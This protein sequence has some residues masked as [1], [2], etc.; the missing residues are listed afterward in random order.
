MIE[1]SSLFVTLSSEQKLHLRYIAKSGSKGPAV[2][3]MHGAVEN[4]KIFYTESNKG[5]APFLASKGYRCYI[6]DLR[7]RG[8]SLPEISRQSDYGQTEAI[9]EDIPA[10]LDYITYHS[11]E[12]PK[13]WVAHSW[14][15]VLM[16]SYFARFKNM[17]DKVAAC[18]YFGSKRSLHN[19]HISKYIQ[20][21]L[22]WYG[23]APLYA[24]KHGFLPAKALRWGSDNETQKSHRQ[25]MEW[26]KRK[27]WIDSDDG[28]DYATTLK[29]MR[30][31]ATLHVAGV[32]DK[33]LAQPVDIKKFMQ[34]SGCGTQKLKMYGQKHGHL[35]D[36]GHIDMLTHKGAHHDQFKDLLDWFA[37]HQHG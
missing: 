35:H 14:G 18:V 6:G 26:A 7:G 19:H 30:L 16:N 12:F 9:L 3:F 22:I 27:P 17:V 25:A 23:L 8:L 21:N 13:F 11:G 33:A 29:N 34:E 37:F 36:Y 24:K 1:Q 10:M 4:G 20:A 2:F 32:K 28:F 31:P 5:L 15:G